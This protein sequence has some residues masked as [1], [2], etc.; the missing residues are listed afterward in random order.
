MVNEMTELARYRFLRAQETL[1]VAKTLLDDGKY[2]DANNRSYYAAFYAIRSVYALKGIDFKKHKTLIATFNKEFVA[3]E[4]FPRSL[5]KGISMLQL[6]REQS[7]YDDMY[8]ASKQESEMQL[9]TAK[10]LIA[11][12]K[13]YLETQNVII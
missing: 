11:L 7:D 1:E 8:V 5:G 10:E 6:I 13:E 4:I 9:S 3:T 12:V 2:R